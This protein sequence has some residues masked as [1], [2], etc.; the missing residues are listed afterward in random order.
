MGLLDK[1]A[2]TTSICLN[3]K[4]ELTFS[5]RTIASTCKKHY[6]NLASDLVKKIPD[7]TV[8]FGISSVRQY[9]KGINFCEKKLRFEK[10]SSVSILKILKEYKTNKA[11]GVDNLAGRFLKDCSNTLCTPIAKIWN[12]SIKLAS[13]PD[14]YKVA[15]IRP[16]YKK[17]FR[18]DPKNFRPIS[19]LPLV[20][21]IIERIIL[22]QTMNFLWDNNVLYKYQSGFR[23]FH[24]KDT[25]LPYLHDKITKGFDSGLL[26]VMVLID[27][28]KAFDTIDHNILIKKNPFC[29]F[30][31]LCNQ[32]VH[33]ISLE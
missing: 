14:K 10:V 27:L 13:F 31:W 4:E 24:S 8:I 25:C 16:L 20:A 6:A 15:K 9:C 28:Q 21:K 19:L 7:P 11:T 26:T 5:P 30:Y 32:V 2:P 29:R 3:T 12:L 18:T 22:D 33:I 23:K 1:K 17:D